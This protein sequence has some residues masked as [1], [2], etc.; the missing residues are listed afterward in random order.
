MKKV[1]A[2]LDKVLESESQASVARKIGISPQY[3]GQVVARK[4]PISEKIL[5]YLGWER[6]VAYR[7]RK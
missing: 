4:H 2:D 5:S 6:Y 3:L 7:R 1:L